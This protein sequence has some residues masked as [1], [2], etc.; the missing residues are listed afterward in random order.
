VKSSDLIPCFNGT[1][2]FAQWLAKLELVAELQ[3]VKEKE[4]FL[5][6]FLAEGAFSVYQG[7][8]KD[9][10]LDYQK[11]KGALQ[12]AFC[13]S[14]GSAYERFRKRD[15]LPGE[16]VDVYLAEICRL[17]R[18]VD[19]NISE[20]LLKHAFVAGLPVAVKYKLKTSDYLSSMSLSSTVEK[21]RVFC[22]DM[23]TDQAL[24]ANVGPVRSRDYLQKTS[25]TISNSRTNLK[26]EVAEAMR[27]HPNALICFKCAKVGH[28]AR[29]CPGLGNE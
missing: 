10:R 17:G 8:E 16:T 18:I 29:A 27:K 26:P 11:L 24:V 28:F 20:L 4:K 13:L 2:D 19:P 15:L 5:P 9:V 6:L 23:G 25:R 14:A 22:E 7:L 1:Q 21:A 12:Q 3:G